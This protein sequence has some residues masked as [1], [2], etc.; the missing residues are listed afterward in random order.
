MIDHSE[1]A[2][3]GELE[4]RVDDLSGPEIAR[5][6]DEHL[7]EMRSVSPPESTHALDLEGLRHPDVVCWTVWQR[8]ELVGC[9]AL[10]R[11]D[12]KHGEIKS[13]RTAFHRRGMGIATR[14][15][16]HI[17]SEAQA[18]GFERLS[19]ETGSFPFFDPARRLYEEFGFEY[20]APFAEYRPDPNSV[21]MTMTIS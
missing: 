11:L 15:L 18:R 8:E 6:L 20:C 13:M 4:I 9:G 17:I 5:F 14:V 3:T 7:R 12:E 2:A 1:T 16:R 10:K 19:L 21:F